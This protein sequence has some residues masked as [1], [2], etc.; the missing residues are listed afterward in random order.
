MSSDAKPIAT[1]QQVRT[2]LVIATF[3]QMFLAAV[4]PLGNDEV[5]YW[6][7]G[8][9]L[10]LSYF[11]HPPGVA[12]LSAVATLL[13]HSIPGNLQARGLP[14]ILHLAA[15]LALFQIYIKLAGGRRTR[16]G[17]LAF[18]AMTQ[19]T[20]AFS[21]GGLVLL[22]DSGLLLFATHGL[23]YAISLRERFELTGHLPAIRQGI[24]LGAIAG[25][26]GLFKYHAA[27]I[28]GGMLVALA[29]SGNW[30][31][32]KAYKFW[33]AVI[34][35][36]LI[37]TLPVWIWNYQND[38]ASLAFQARRG[39]VDA[40]LDLARAVRTVAGEFIFLTPGFFGLLL[41]GF[42]E[43]W[44]HRHRDINRLIFWSTLPLLVI[45]HVTMLY[46]EV[47]PHWALPAFWLLIPQA[48]SVAG[49]SWQSRKVIINSGVALCLSVALSGL[50]GIPTVRQSLVKQMNGHPGALGELTYWPHLVDS[51]QWL[52]LVESASSKLPVS[53]VPGCPE[54]LSLASYR[55]FT[56]AQMAWSLPGH[57]KVRSFEAG[58]RYYYHDRDKG[59]STPGCP[60]LA[61]GEAAHADDNAI[62]QKM[63]VIAEGELIDRDY[64]DRRLVWKVGYLK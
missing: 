38:F 24:V 6:D 48:A 45:V 9:D 41:L 56:V 62:T 25:L 39:A 37:M 32:R 5:Y 22:P 23:L 60:V 63:D 40:Q 3:V 42:F 36:G 16:R 27:P 52:M 19:L 55:W 54:R 59:L 35:T 30:Q 17:D 51:G 21:I 2:W 57:P 31:L 1:P 11:D 64:Q 49:T 7:W 12:W 10:Q 13:F 61:V 15:S 46:K 29:A 34:V 8:R 44:P 20:P 50:T 14:P 58:A 53:E 26:A 18:F 43:L 47:L 28:F 33:L 4:I